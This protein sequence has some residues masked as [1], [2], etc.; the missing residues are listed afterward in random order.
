MKSFK[1]SVL[2]MLV[3]A[4]M[5]GTVLN[6]QPTGKKFQGIAGL[7]EDQKA[8]IHKLRVSHLKDIQTIKN[9]VG[10]NRAHY[11]TLMTSESP[12]MNAINKNIDEFGSLRTQLLKKQAAHTQDIRKLLTDEQRLIFDQRHAERGNQQG[13]GFKGRE[14]HSA[15]PAWS[16]SKKRMTGVD[17]GQQ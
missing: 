9:Q 2:F 1:I 7:S 16:K 14:N 12:D 13:R 6:A 5:A 15:G 11:K 10:E 17:G 3:L 4:L 8:Q